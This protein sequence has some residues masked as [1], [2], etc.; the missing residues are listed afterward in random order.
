MGLKSEGFVEVESSNTEG[1][2]VGFDFRYSRNASYIEGPYKPGGPFGEFYLGYTFHDAK[3]KVAG[4]LESDGKIEALTSRYQY[5]DNR[6]VRGLR[7]GEA[8][9]PSVE[10][11]GD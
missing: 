1:M 3:I 5:A 6:T 8:P 2:R 10:S 4:E 9:I 7:G 11:G